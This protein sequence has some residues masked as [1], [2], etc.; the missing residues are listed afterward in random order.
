MA[1]DMVVNQEYANYG[2]NRLNDEYRRLQSKTGDQK[3]DRAMRMFYVLSAYTLAAVVDTCFSAYGLRTGQM[4]ETANITNYLIQNL[5]LCLG[6]FAPKATGIL[7]TAA[8]F[9]AIEEGYSKNLHKWRPE[10][11]FYASA[12]YTA[13]AGTKWL[14]E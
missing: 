1:L 8:A 4:Y 6:L 3:P 7:L 2:S 10:P 9:K 11:F 5:G 12:I 13:L 14:F